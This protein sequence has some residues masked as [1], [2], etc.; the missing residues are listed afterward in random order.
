[1]V[2]LT[3]LDPQTNAPLQ[4]WRFDQESLIWIGRALENHVVLTNPLVSRRHIEL[5]RQGQGWHFVNH[6]AN[7]VY[8]EGKTTNQGLLTATTALQLARGGPILRCEW[9]GAT[10]KGPT[11]SPEPSTAKALAKA[12]S[13]KATLELPPLPKAAGSGAPHLATQSDMPFCT[14]GGN[15]PDALLCAHCGLP[16]RV[17]R[18]VRQYQV[19]RVLGRGGMGTT[20]LAWNPAIATRPAFSPAIPGAAGSSQAGLLVLKEMNADMAQNPKACELFEREA[21]TLQTLDHPGIPRYYDFFIEA[22]KS[23]LAMELI[24]G[25]DLEKRVLQKGPVEV[26]QAIA[27]MLQTCEILDYLHHHPQPMIHRDIKPGNLLVQTMTN[28]VVLLDFGAVTVAGMA[29]GTRIGAEG[30]S[31]PEQTQGRPVVQSDL[32]AIGPTLIFLLTGQKPQRFYKR[33]GDGFGFVVDEIAE[34]PAGL[35]PVIKRLTELRPSDRYSSA[36]ELAEALTRCPLV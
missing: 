35:K 10:I 16:I 24:H 8:I 4:Q 15:A 7:G 28:Q 21:A 27:W 1:M 11:A 5:R 34:I 26:T 25:Q 30:Y 23:Y 13:A 18:K 17:E 22:G 36:A 29:L 9:D 3:L 32:Y 31:A 6:G 19:L 2:I 14:H 33:R 12:P 20:Y